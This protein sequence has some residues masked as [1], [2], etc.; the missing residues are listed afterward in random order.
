M[1]IDYVPDPTDP[2]HKAT[3]YQRECLQ[4]IYEFFKSNDNIAAYPSG[5]ATTK[6]NW[7]P[8]SITCFGEFHEALKTAHGDNPLVD[9]NSLQRINMTSVVNFSAGNL[10]TKYEIL[11]STL[12]KQTTMETQTS[13][14][15][16][17]FMADAH[18][19]R[20]QWAT[21]AATTINDAR[22]PRGRLLALWQKEGSLKLNRQNNNIINYDPNDTAISYGAPLLPLT[23]EH[24]KVCYVIDASFEATG[25]DFMFPTRRP[26][27]GG[28]NE[29]DLSDYAAALTHIRT[30]ADHYGGAGSADRLFNALIV[31]GTPGNYTIGVNAEAFYTELL[32]H[33]GSFYL[34]RWQPEGPDITYIA[35]NLG[36]PKLRQMRRAFGGATYAER[37]RLSFTDWA[38]HYE[39]RDKEWD[40]IRRN[41]ARF[42]AFRNYFERR[43]L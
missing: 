27:G 23:A 42:H 31:A 39:I 37:A 13:I 40:Q 30:K 4:S 28:D 7:L 29:V 35:Y 11:R 22:L 16:P 12:A 34:E 17:N 10:E 5:A 26:P 6:T 33:V 18:P 32:V 38:M 25:S 1:I 19:A 41:A 20:V 24:A 9:L 15:N 14:F 36:G 3:A 2:N 43:Y 21:T 8:P